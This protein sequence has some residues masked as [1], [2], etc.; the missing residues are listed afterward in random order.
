MGT[1]SANTYD[2]YLSRLANAPIEAHEG[3]SG[4]FSAPSKTLDPR[5]FEGQHFRP[6]VRQQILANLYNFWRTKYHAPERWSTVWAAGSGISY[7]WAADRGNG[8]L[9]ILVGVDFVKFVMYNPDYDGIPQTD[10]ADI[11]DSQLVNE[12]WPQTANF[13]GHYELTYFVNSGATDIRNIHPYAAYD[14]THDRWTIH[15]PVLPQDPSTLYPQEW[16]DEANR[17]ISHVKGMLSRY[18]TLEQQAQSYTVNSPGWLNTVS[19]LRVT[20]SQLQAAWDDVHLGRKEA[21]GP[22][23]SGYGD[24]HNYVWQKYKQ[25]GLEDALRSVSAV[26]TGAQTATEQS[27][28]GAPIEDAH[29]ALSEA[30]LSNRRIR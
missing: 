8:D 16:K 25:A 20:A 9:D 23:G 29:R 6:E 24:W 13:L 10:M 14:L 30:A 28:Y 22:Q 19:Q 3:G 17:R 26:V 11:F 1:M 18:N 15:P 27:L 12:L 4:Y 7:Q 21:F 2:F 5:L